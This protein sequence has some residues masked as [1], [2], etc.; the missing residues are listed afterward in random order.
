MIESFQYILNLPK[1]LLFFVIKLI[2][3]FSNTI[4]LPW[5]KICSNELFLKY[6]PS[7]QNSLPKRHIIELPLKTIHLGH[8]LVA[9]FRGDYQ[10]RELH[11]VEEIEIDEDTHY[12]K[13]SKVIEK[14][15]KRAVLYKDLQTI[16][17][18]YKII[19]S[20]K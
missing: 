18:D 8:F 3:A 12:K 7:C 14:K 2:V 17:N 4:P 6:S 1:N 15:V 13:D 9:F 20:S 19:K 16:R 10:K 5:I 11:T